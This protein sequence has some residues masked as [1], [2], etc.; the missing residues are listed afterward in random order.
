MKKCP[1]C[2]RTKIVGVE[3]AYGSKYRYDGVSE[4][5]CVNS[6]CGYR[7][8]RFCGNELKGR[9]VEPVLCTHKGLHPLTIELNDEWPLH[10]WFVGY[11]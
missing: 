6:K 3:Y 11:G 7:Q 9:E 8:G 5:V 1:K 10:R 2:G 4:W